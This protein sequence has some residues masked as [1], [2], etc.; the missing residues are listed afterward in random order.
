MRVFGRLKE[1]PRTPFLWHLLVV[2]WRE[3]IINISNKRDPHLGRI[4]SLQ[5]IADKVGFN[6]HLHHLKGASQD[7]AINIR[8][9]ELVLRPS[10]IWKLHEIGKGVLVK[11]KR[12]L[13]AV[14]SPIR[15]LRG[16]IEEHFE[17]DLREIRDK[18]VSV[19]L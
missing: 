18:I 4:V 14:T 1:S 17:A 5:D 13:I 16:D 8:I 15:D 9:P 2:F 6:L 7:T 19:F 10:I 11:D 3:L 12:E